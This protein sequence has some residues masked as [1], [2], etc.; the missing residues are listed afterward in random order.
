M[1]EEARKS[2][3]SP[4][5]LYNLA[6]THRR[7]GHVAEALELYH[8]YVAAVPDAS[9]RADLSDFERLERRQVATVPVRAAA[10]SRCACRRPTTSRSAPGSFSNTTQPKGS[11]SS[12][13]SSRQASA[14]TCETPMNPTR[15]IV[16]CLAASMSVTCAGGSTGGVEYPAN[17]QTFDAGA[18]PSIT[19]F[20]SSAKSGDGTI[21]A[22]LISGPPPISR[23]PAPALTVAA[24]GFTIP[25][26][27]K[28]VG[29]NA[30]ANTYTRVLLKV[31]A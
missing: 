4:S 11:N 15:A 18:L 12:L 13:P 19:Q 31:N 17:E 30:G 26:G 7:A 16:L 8:A 22:Q 2:V 25:G 10:A 1:F 14:C 27:S 5:L 21:Q 29:L 3:N 6:E 9:K 28:I 24:G 23:N 20:I